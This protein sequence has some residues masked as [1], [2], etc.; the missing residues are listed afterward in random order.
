M[1]ISCDFYYTENNSGNSFVIIKG[2]GNV[3]IYNLDEIENI[4]EEHVLNI[5]SICDC[6]NTKYKGKQ[7]KDSKSFDDEFKNWSVNLKRLKDKK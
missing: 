2:I 1:G 6:Y 4:N 5:N 7:K 3:N